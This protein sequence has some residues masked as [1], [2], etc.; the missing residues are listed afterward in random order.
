MRDGTA[1]LIQH[2]KGV[3]LA[4]LRS[5]DLSQ[6]TMT[7]SGSGDSGQVDEIGVAPWSEDVLK[8][9]VTMRYELSAFLPDEKRWETRLTDKKVTLREALRDFA[10]AVIYLHAAGFENNDGGSGELTLTVED[11]SYHLD[12]TTYYTESASEEFVG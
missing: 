6:A 10:D 4:A 5:L 3:L 2:N 9:F 11:D 12:H 7:Y 8:S 1:D